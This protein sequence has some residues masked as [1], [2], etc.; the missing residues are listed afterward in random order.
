MV[1]GDMNKLWLRLGFCALVVLLFSLWQGF[2]AVAVVTTI[3]LASSLFGILFSQ[4]EERM[5]DHNSTFRNWLLSYE[6]KVPTHGLDSYFCLFI[7][8]TPKELYHAIMDHRLLDEFYG[9]MTRELG[10]F[11]GRSHVKR[12][13]REQLVIIKEFPS[14]ENLDFKQRQ[15]YQQE[16]TGRIEGILEDLIASSDAQ[17]GRSIDI[18]V[19]CA[20]GGIRYRM[21]RIEDLLE[22]SFHTMNIARKEGKT[23]LIA[24]EHIRARKYDIDEC[25][26]GFTRKGW[27]NEFNPFFQ[28]IIDP[29]TFRVIGMESM[30]RWQLGGFRVMPAAVFKDLAHETARLGKID[31]IIIEKTLSTVRSLYDED[32]LP[33]GFRIVVNVSASSLNAHSAEWLGN[34][35][36]GFGL[37]PEHVEI[38]IKD[39]I[40]SDPTVAKAIESLKTHGFRIA[41]DAFDEESFDIKAFFNSCFDI[42]KLD[43]FH[44]GEDGKTSQEQKRKV[45]DSLAILGENLSMQVLAKNIETR[46]QLEC[47]REHGVDFL[48]GNYF[49]PAVPEVEFRNFLFKYR[50]GLFLDAYVGAS[51]LA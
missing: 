36:T 24:D 43:Y 3:C 15:I 12:L 10:V 50:E 37:H 32:L 34:L 20:S 27:E 35:T 2:F 23:C 42:I 9:S 41:L 21:E 5:F 8:S 25:K 22:L 17:V 4:D 19:G 26:A 47:A 31:A 39:S 29:T 13:S 14:P 49:T 46:E 18:A 51:E 28:P 11:L 40:L 44:S 33:Y 30:A 7:Q 16:M 1:M 45:F 6:K 48:Q 38:D